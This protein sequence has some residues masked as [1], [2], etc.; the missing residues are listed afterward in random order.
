MNYHWRSLASISCSFLFSIPN[1]HFQLSLVFRWP[2]CQRAPDANNTLSLLWPLT[3]KCNLWQQQQEQV[4]EPR[5]I[6]AGFWAFSLFRSF[7]SGRLSSTYN[8]PGKLMLQGSVGRGEELEVG[9]RVA[10]GVDYG[11]G[12]LMVENRNFTRKVLFIDVFQVLHNGSLVL[13]R[14]GL[15]DRGDYT[16]KAA[17]KVFQLIDIDINIIISRLMMMS[18]AWCRLETQ[19]RRLS[20]SR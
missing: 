18:T 4:S 17:N 3:S 14:V 11:G 6:P 5:I 9:V 20:A 10:D 12:A 2:E 15:Q 7:C 19:S 1:N 13:W 16:C 8:V